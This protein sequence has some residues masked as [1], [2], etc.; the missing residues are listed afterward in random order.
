LPHLAAPVLVE[1]WFV[2][3]AEVTI[4]CLA[5]GWV[6]RAIVVEGQ[7]VRGIGARLRS[8]PIPWVP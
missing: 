7:D 3:L 6:R 4:T 2:A 8:G 5:V 1:R